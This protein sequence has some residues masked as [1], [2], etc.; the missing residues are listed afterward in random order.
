ME[1]P[2]G[3]LKINCKY[4]LSYCLRHLQQVRGG[5]GVTGRSE[6]PA[7][8]LQT[9][10]CAGGGMGDLLRH[11]IT[12][13]S[14]RL[15]VLLPLSSMEWLAALLVISF[16]P[17]FLSFPTADW[18]IHNP[19]PPSTLSND[20]PSSGLAVGSS[21]IDGWGVAAAVSKIKFTRSGTSGPGSSRHGPWLIR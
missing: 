5:W 16:I 21:Q 7:V 18:M 3:C 19:N 1:R 12:N 14:K 10:F 13:K 8:H 6:L 20:R 2:C 17:F 15:N 9:D 11:F 4:L